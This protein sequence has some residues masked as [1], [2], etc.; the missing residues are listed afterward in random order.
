VR[1]PEASALAWRGLGWAMDRTVEPG[2]ALAAYRQAV[3]LNPSDA[4]SRFG[5]G[6]VLANTGRWAEAAAEL[7]A[8]FRL[9]PGRSDFRRALDAVLLRER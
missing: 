8:A 1:D 9:D 5:A 2:R 4:D 7:E 6:M 3:G